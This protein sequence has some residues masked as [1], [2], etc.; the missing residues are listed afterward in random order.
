MTDLSES[1]LGSEY[2]WTCPAH[3]LV[4]PRH[5]FDLKCIVILQ[6]VSN[7]AA[8][9]QRQCS[10]SLFLHEIQYRTGSVEKFQKFTEILSVLR[11]FICRHLWYESI[12]N[13]LSFKSIIPIKGTASRRERV[14]THL[15]QHQQGDQRG[16]PWD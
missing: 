13:F 8:V 15:S 7:V 2:S 1:K 12:I 10:E 6:D 16:K 9:S 3:K 11:A 5:P 14:T 4:A